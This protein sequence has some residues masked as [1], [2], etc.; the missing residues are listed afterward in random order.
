MFLILLLFLLFLTCSCSS[1]SWPASVPPG[2]DLLLFMTCSCSSLFWP[3]SAHDLLLI[4]ISSCSHQFLASTLSLPSPV[5]RR[6]SVPAVSRWAL[7]PNLKHSAV[8]SSR[9]RVTSCQS[10]STANWQDSRNC[11]RPFLGDPWLMLSAGSRHLLLILQ[12]TT[13]A[14]ID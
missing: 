10:C 13:R 2:S 3:T 9:S 1:C 12:K 11:C 8:S 5:A 6:P 14:K 7:I 4:L